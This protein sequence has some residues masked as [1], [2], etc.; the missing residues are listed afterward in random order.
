MDYVISAQKHIWGFYGVAQPIKDASFFHSQKCLCFGLSMPRCLP[1]WSSYW[2][3]LRKQQ[4]RAQK[5]F[6]LYHFFTRSINFKQVNLTKLPFKWKKVSRSVVCFI[7]RRATALISSDSWL[8]FR[9]PCFFR[10]NQGCKNRG[11]AVWEMVPPGELKSD[12]PFIGWCGSKRTVA[13]FLKPF[14]MREI[15]AKLTGPLTR[16]KLVEYILGT[17]SK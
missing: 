10:V 1:V 14:K 2:P 16:G 3:F 13:I 4:Q 5:S 11:T 8:Y 7:R 6:D 9:K 15:A 12:A 17:D